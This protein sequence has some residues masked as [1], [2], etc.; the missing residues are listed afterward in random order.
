MKEIFDKLGLTSMK[1][2]AAIYSHPEAY[3]P[4]FN[5]IVELSKKAEAGVC[6]C[7][8]SCKKFDFIAFE[9][10]YQIC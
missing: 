8:K 6:D 4:T 5:A 9:C 7:Q 10:I 1:I 2:V 3:P